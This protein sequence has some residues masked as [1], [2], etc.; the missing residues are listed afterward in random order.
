MPLFSFIQ[1]T[2]HSDSHNIARLCLTI[3]SNI[4]FSVLLKDTLTGGVDN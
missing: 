1:D 4:G 3:Q 2:L